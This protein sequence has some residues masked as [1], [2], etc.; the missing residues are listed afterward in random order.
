MGVAMQHRTIPIQ[1][2]ADVDE[3]ITADV[4][5][6]LNTSS[7]ASGQRQVAEVRG[8]EALMTHIGASDGAL[9]AGSY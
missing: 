4:V 5:V 6:Y 1:V 3:E 9:A 7:Q 2:W 8:R